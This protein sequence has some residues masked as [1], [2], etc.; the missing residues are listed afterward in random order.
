MLFKK[1]MGF[2]LLGLATSIVAN[3]TPISA[4]QTNFPAKDYIETIR[5]M[6]LYSNRINDIFLTILA[7]EYKSYALF[8][9]NF[10]PDYTMA[11]HFAIKSINAYH[12]EHVKPEDIYKRKLPF[13]S[14]VELS[15]AHDDLTTLLNTDLVNKYPQLMA[16]AQAKFDCW[17]DS[18]ASGLGKRQSA[19]CRNR[20]LKAKKYLFEKLSDCCNCKKD[21]KVKHETVVSKKT[22]KYN[23]KIL[24]IKKWP[25]LPTVSNNPPVP[26]VRQVVIKE[27]TVSKEIKEA[28]LKIEKTI[29]DINTKLANNQTKSDIE[30]IKQQISELKQTIKDSSQEDFNELQEKLSELENKLSSISCSEPEPVEYENKDKNDDKPS[31]IEAIVEIESIDDEGTEEVEEPEISEESEEYEETEESEEP[32]EILVKEFKEEI[33]DSDEGTSDDEY[34]EE[35]ED[36]EEDPEFET[37]DED[38]YLE[39]EIQDSSSKL[40]PYEVFFDWN[41]ASVKPKFNDALKEIAQNAKKSKEIIVIKGHTDASGSRE[42]NQKLSKKRAENVGKI[43]MS[44]GIPK[45]KIILQGV[46]S[47]EPK[48]KT[49]LGEKNAENRR[50]LIK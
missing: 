8:K 13:S 21:K 32:E 25:N 4:K 45:D 12:G 43:I 14:I 23:G 19:S 46:G 50:V 36:N 30:N 7:N 26:V 1:H 28:I 48:V 47:S 38:E 15:R 40:L 27:L 42:Y 11:N 2:F 44:Y 5:S 41:D 31:Y 3:S 16:E 24:P 22:E 29:K 49:K 33:D 37:T 18:E 9:A 10:T 39:I 34:L 35:D 20:F 6:D 17:A